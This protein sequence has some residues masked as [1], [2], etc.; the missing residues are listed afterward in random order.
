MNELSNDDSLLEFGFNDTF[1]WQKKN[2]DDICVYVLETSEGTTK[3]GV[4]NNFLSRIKQIE[5]TERL[6]IL[7]V[8][9][10]FYMPRDS[11][12]DL[13]SW[14]H[15]FFHFQLAYKNEYFNITFA[16]GVDKLREVLKNPDLNQEFS[17]VP[18]LP[19]FREEFKKF[20]EN[21]FLYVLD[22]DQYAVYKD[23]HWIFNRADYDGRSILIDSFWERMWDKIDGFPKNEATIFNFLCDEIKNVSSV[24]FDCQPYLLNC[25]NGVVDL[26]DGSLHPHDPDKLFS[27]YTN[28]EYLGLDYRNEEAEKFLIDTLPDEETRNALI[29]YLG[30]CLTGYNTEKTVMSLH[31]WR[32]LDFLAFLAFVR[33]IFGDYCS[34][35]QFILEDDRYPPDDW[36]DYNFFTAKVKDVKWFRLI[37]RSRL[38]YDGKLDTVKKPFSKQAMD[39]F[40]NDYRNT[41]KILPDY[42]HF[43]TKALI[44]DRE[45]KFQNINDVQRILRIESG[46]TPTALPCF[47]KKVKSAFLTM[48]VKGAMEWFKASKGGTQK[49][50]IESRQ[51]KEFKQRYLKQHG[52]RDSKNPKWYYDRTGW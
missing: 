18:P 52:V 1:S 51:M 48:L 47:T 25:A 27:L 28:V 12:F 21:K 46:Y 11:A 35:S 37:Q 3:I 50:L 8:C 40:T 29:R 36:K 30:Y 41:P 24:D 26:R 44:L 13:E 49:G 33:D 4:S 9:H 16:E 10:S 6:S 19:M 43:P 17:N 39:V 7:R 22:L 31:A 38:V 20:V 45:L 42:I 14:L 15:K 2:A 34:P 23:N 32:I 5:Y